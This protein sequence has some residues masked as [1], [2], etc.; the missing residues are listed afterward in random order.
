MLSSTH[1]ILTHLMV[2]ETKKLQV[3]VI[4]TSGPGDP[5]QPGRPVNPGSPYEM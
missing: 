5:L 3:I 2:Q 1:Y 4:L